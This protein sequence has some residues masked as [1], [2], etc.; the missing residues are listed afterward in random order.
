MLKRA[1]TIATVAAA[2][3]TICG[4]DSRSGVLTQGW[5]PLPWVGLVPAVLLGA[6]LVCVAVYPG[7]TSKGEMTCR[8]LAAGSGPRADQKRLN[9]FVEWVN[10]VALNRAGALKASVILLAVGTM[11][12]PLPFI[13]QSQ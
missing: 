2:V 7:S 1:E 4:F 10:S 6:S 12:F 3:A 8:A 13:F 5:G 11:C 9:T